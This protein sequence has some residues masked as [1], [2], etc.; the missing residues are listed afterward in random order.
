MDAATGRLVELLQQLIRNGCVSR[1]FPS[2]GEESRNA[3]TLEAVLDGPGLELQKVEPVPGRAALVARIEGSDP[4][5]PSLCLLG[6]TDVVPVD[7]SGWSRNPFGGE[8]V[9]GE[10][11]GRGAVDMLN[12][13][14]AMGLAVRRLADSGFRPK[15]SLVYVA[16]PDEECGGH[17]GMR[18][19]VEQHRDLV[20][21]DYAV[22]EIGGAVRKTP[23]GSTIECYVA[24]KGGAGIRV[25]VKG[26]PSHSSVPWG[27][28][29]AVVTAVEVVRRL[30]AW[31]SPT[32][33]LPEWESWVRAQQYPPETEALL[34]DPDRLYDGLGSLPKALAGQAHAC[35]HN[36]VAPTI[37]QAGE[38]I[39][40]IPGRAVIAVNVRILPGQDPD[41]VLAD[42]RDLF[43]DMGDAVELEP[44]TLQAGSSSPVDTPL[45]AALEGVARRHHPDAVLVPSL[46][47]GAT[48]A[49]WLRPIGTPTYG[50][51]VLSRKVTPTEYW[52]RFHG[53]DERIDVESLAMSLAGW[54]QLAS[55]F[56]A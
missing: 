12:Q 45:W 44:M 54:E 56:L 47:V 5:A 6:H 24:E 50:F 8:L 9:D 11:W 13:T 41:A 3:E 14:A 36:T 55:T 23:S 42:L 39:N 26:T 38:K 53:H 35:T 28:D 22:T 34:L 33:I 21:A 32:T 2:E 7:P 17:Q 27:A 18:L 51:G 40:V 30:A 37:I 1:G 48:D 52:A 49:R 29:N 31:R 43:T 4:A 16:T 46:C 20:Q 25:H 10:V 19:L 15:G